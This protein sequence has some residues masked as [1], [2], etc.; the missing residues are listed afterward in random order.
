MT[1]CCCTSCSPTQFPFHSSLLFYVLPTSSLHP[2]NVGEAIIAIG[3]LA[4]A[5]IGAGGPQRGV[6]LRPYRSR[7]WENGAAT[8]S[9][10]RNALQ[11]RSKSGTAR[12]IVQPQ[13][14]AAACLLVTFTALPQVQNTPRLS[15]NTT[16]GTLTPNSTCT[17]LDKT[18]QVTASASA[19]IGSSDLLPPQVLDGGVKMC[20]FSL[21]F[22]LSVFFPS[23]ITCP[24]DWV[25]VVQSAGNGSLFDICWVG[26]L[27][28]KALIIQSFLP[29]F[30]HPDS[31]GLGAFGPISNPV[32]FV[33]ARFSTF[34]RTI[35]VSLPQTS[36]F[37]PLIIPHMTVQNQITFRTTAMIV[38]PAELCLRVT[39]W[40]VWAGGVVEVLDCPLV[41]AEHKPKTINV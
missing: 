30:T 16:A 7:L 24:R 32:A 39:S 15:T 34:L 18:P 38:K 5:P 26:R 27:E 25:T 6:Q 1:V 9:D 14:P 37:S 2:G 4:V 11:R 23:I 28:E 17:N 40:K 36:L 31:C 22:S 12:D 13:T 19:L 10:I 35:L 33:K 41:H 8:P 3:S 29:L 20:F 21:C